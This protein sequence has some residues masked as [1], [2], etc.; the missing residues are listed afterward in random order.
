MEN[1]VMEILN[2]EDAK[3][4][5]SAFIGDN[6]PIVFVTGVTGQDG[7]HMVDYLLKNTN[8]LV[9]GGARRLSIKNHD[10]IK[11]L[12]NNSRFYYP[13]QTDNIQQ[14]LWFGQHQEL[15]R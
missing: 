2:I 11:H 15:I 13:L 14:L 10:N 12:E 8:A 5:K 6:V 1:Y 3:N 4:I 9:F 7:S